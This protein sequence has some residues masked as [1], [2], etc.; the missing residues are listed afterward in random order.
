MSP[1]LIRSGQV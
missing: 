1:I